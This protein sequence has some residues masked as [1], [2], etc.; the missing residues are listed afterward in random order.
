MCVCKCKF[1]GLPV[2]W[3]PG[4]A[5]SLFSPLHLESQPIFLQT[6]KA[7]LR[8]MYYLLLHC[9]QKPTCEMF[10]FSTEDYLYLV[11]LPDNTFGSRT[12]TFFLPARVTLSQS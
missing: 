9:H 10:N 4:L 7:L 6:D 1:H 3:K 11:D 5:L 8:V 2:K 12:E